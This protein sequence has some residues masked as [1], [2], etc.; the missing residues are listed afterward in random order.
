MDINTGFDKHNV[1]LMGIDPG[2]AGYQTDS[3]LE[4]M[5]QRVEEL[6]SSLPGIQ[7]VSFAYFVFN[8]GGFTTDN[9]TVPG[10]PKS[11]EHPSVDHNIVGPRYLDVM[12]MPVI[13]GRALS[14]HDSE[15]SRKVAVINETMA[16]TYFP[17]GSPLGRTFGFE[18]GGDDA[19][20]QNIE[21]VGVV[22]DA[23]Y[24]DLEE[25]QMPAAFYPHS[26]H[27]PHFLFNFVARYTGNPK[28]L[29]PE[30]RKAVA[31]I[32]PNLPVGDVTTLAQVVDDN[33]SNKR[34]IAQLST[35]FG[36]LAAFLACIGIYGVMSYGI[37][38]RT[39]E[40]G[41]RMALGAERCHVLWVVLRETLWLVVAG[42]AIG[43][44]LALAAGRL[45]ESALFGLKSD[46]PLAVGLAM[47]LMI[48]VALLA[49]YVPARRATRIDP[50][51][52]LRHE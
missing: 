51:V 16:R 45:V 40:F 4:S 3:R 21:V 8:R 32:D 18:P 12:K 15:S 1:L 44:V 5:M 29:F 34:L 9:V 41:I 24:M 35:I 10:R 22:K 43:L 6:V 33:V 48:A 49:A 50:S 38:R 42:V 19:E 46:D 14:S 20:W 28:L 52:A 31:E 7:G 2:S 27:H 23:K 47:L 11:E 26:Q 37:T 13:L 25:K 30:I 36:I 39:N 17:G